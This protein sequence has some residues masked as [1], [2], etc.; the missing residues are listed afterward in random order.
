M[1]KT[2]KFHIIEFW[3]IFWR[4]FLLDIA[5]SEDYC[6][7]H[8]PTRLWEPAMSNPKKGVALGVLYPD[9]LHRPF[10]KIKF[11]FA[12][13]VAPLR[14]ICEIFWLNLVG[15]FMLLNQTSALEILPKSPQK[16]ELQNE[17]AIFVLKNQNLQV[18]CRF[19][20]CS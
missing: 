12:S 11:K 16:W 18:R 1:K 8:K 15:C 20:I 10:Y 4:I 9:F 7:R 13:L 17:Y 14:K 2:G 6:R 19:G 3:D 5:I